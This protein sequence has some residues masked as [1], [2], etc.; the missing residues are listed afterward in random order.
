ML[1]TPGSA[2]ASVILTLLTDGAIRLRLGGAQEQA[3]SGCFARAS[4]YYWRRFDRRGAGAR[5][6]VS[7]CRVDLV[8]LSAFSRACSAGPPRAPATRAAAGLALPS[9]IVESARASNEELFETFIGYPKPLF[10]AV[11][12]AAPPGTAP[13][14]PAALPP[15]AMPTAQRLW[16]VLPSARQ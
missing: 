1:R 15:P 11:N 9:T 2:D 8:G 13:P 5:P 4:D 12:G 7:P 6:R 16:Q 3:A 10:A 14:T